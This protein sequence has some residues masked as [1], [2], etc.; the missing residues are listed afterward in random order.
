MRWPGF[1]ITFIPQIYVIF[2]SCKTINC[3]SRRF[4]YMKLKQ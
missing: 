2:F 3:G 1:F 4:I